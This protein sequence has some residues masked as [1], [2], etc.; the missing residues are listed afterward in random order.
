MTKNIL[1]TL[2]LFI[3]GVSLAQKNEFGIFIGSSGYHGDI[4]HDQIGEVLF[5]QSPAIGFVHKINFHDY[6]SFRTSLQ[7]GTIKADDALSKHP[8]T[9]ARNLSF[10][11]RILDLNM[12]FEFN[13]HRFMIRKRKTVYSPYIFAGLSFFAFNPQAQNSSGQWVNLQSLGTEGQG[14]AASSIN[15]YSLSNW[16]IP[17]GLGYKANFGKKL[18][19]SIEWTW[20]AA[21]TDYL[22]DVSGYYVDETYLSEE[23]A[24]MANPGTIDITTGKTRGNPNNN[25]WYNFTGFTISYK[26][27][28]KPKKCPKALLP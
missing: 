12:G 22:D 18:T 6:L 5:H 1:I 25:D 4:G 16:A 11:S 15:K 28:N 10:R 14:T 24:E 3:S 17:F 8:N 13:F 2:I 27:K 21:Q 26:I 20:R 7:T 23:T 19:L 9:Q